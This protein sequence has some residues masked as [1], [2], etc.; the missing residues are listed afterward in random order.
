MEKKLQNNLSYALQF[1]DRTRFMVS[2][3]SNPVN[4]LSEGIH[5]IKCKFRHDDKKCEACEIKYKF[6]DCLLEDTNFTDDLIAYKCLY[7]NKN[8]QHKFDFY[9]HLNMEDITDADYAHAKRVCKD[10]EIKKLEKYHDLYIQS[11]TLSLADVFENFRAPGLALQ[12]ALKKTKVKLGPLTD[13]NMLL[14]VEK[15][16]RG[17]ICHSI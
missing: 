6:C 5:R 4:N 7:C 15:G 2:L 14:M 11:D 13:I 9:S 1:N 10:F 12:A 3:L 17:Q 16:I 8:Y